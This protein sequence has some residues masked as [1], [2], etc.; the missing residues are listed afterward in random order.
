GASTRVCAGAGERNYVVVY[1]HAEYDGTEHGAARDLKK[2]DPGGQADEQDHQSQ[3]KTS[4]CRFFHSLAEEA[5]DDVQE[6]R[7]RH[8][9]DEDPDD[10][11]S[12]DHLAD[13]EPGGVQA[14]VTVTAHRAGEISGQGSVL[15][16]L[17]NCS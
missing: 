5:A 1:D 17:A 6:K 13:R 16:N 2:P 10:D 15:G 12:H 4:P 11:E 14:Q 7:S 3:D 9:N 8:E